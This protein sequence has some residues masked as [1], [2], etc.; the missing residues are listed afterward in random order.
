MAKEFGHQGVAV[1]MTGMGDDGAEGMGDVKE[2][3]G[4]TLTQSEESCVVYGMPKSAVERGYS[5][6]TVGLKELPQVLQSL[7][8]PERGR[9]AAAADQRY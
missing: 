6:R 9:R 7:A 2:A 3:G 4:M 1:L 8:E 5:L